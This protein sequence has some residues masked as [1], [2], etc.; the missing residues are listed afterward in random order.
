MASSALLKQSPG[1]HPAFGP[2]GFDLSIQ[3]R[4]HV[5][6]PGLGLAPLQVRALQFDLHHLTEQLPDFLIPLEFLPRSHYP[7]AP[8]FFIFFVI[9]TD[10]FS[11]LLVFLLFQHLSHLGLRVRLAFLLVLGH[12]LW[13]RPANGFLKFLERLLQTPPLFTEVKFSCAFDQGILAAGQEGSKVGI[14]PG[15]GLAAQ[16]PGLRLYAEPAP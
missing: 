7:P 2:E 6:L 12:L 5:V 14:H 10:P 15:T 16:L 11:L 3:K 13:H 8:L 1:L 4:L 9:R